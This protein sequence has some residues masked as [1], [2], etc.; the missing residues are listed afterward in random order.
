MANDSSNLATSS[1]P[2]PP[3]STTTGASPLLQLGFGDALM[4]A[5]ATGIVYLATAAYQIGYQDHFGFTPKYWGRR[6]KYFNAALCGRS[7]TRRQFH[8]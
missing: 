2:P 3:N 8:L 7:D 5:F 4:L 1:T 6:F